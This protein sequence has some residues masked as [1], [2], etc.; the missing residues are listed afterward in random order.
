MPVV[1]VDVLVEEQEVAIGHVVV[2]VVP[3]GGLAFHQRLYFVEHFVRHVA[4]SRLDVH[5]GVCWPRSVGF[6]INLD[7]SDVC[8]PQV[9]GRL[10]YRFRLINVV[11][12]NLE[13]WVV[14]NAGTISGTCA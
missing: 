11:A 13:A 2:C 6:T 9:A 12:V 10:N 4:D 5:I 7:T 14:V 8:L 1:R 3:G